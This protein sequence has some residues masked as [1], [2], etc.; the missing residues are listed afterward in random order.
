MTE[1]I[2]ASAA[3]CIIS[4]W[5]DCYTTIL[6]YNKVKDTSYEANMIVRFLMNK[7]GVKTSV[8][9]IFLL[10]SYIIVK[11]TLK[12]IDAP[13]EKQ[14]GLIGVLTF[15]TITQSMIAYSNYTGRTNIIV[16]MIIR[17]I[18]IYWIRNNKNSKS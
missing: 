17:I 14:I 18:P 5:F 13:M 7:I 8:W 6:G 10:A 4:K 12:D 3:L 2:I 9:L 11:G 16:K 15:F 1:I